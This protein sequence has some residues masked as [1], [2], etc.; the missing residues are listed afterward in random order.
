MTKDELI[1]L[2]KKISSLSEEELKE[3]ELNECS[4]C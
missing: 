1:E 3:V 2:K 4:K